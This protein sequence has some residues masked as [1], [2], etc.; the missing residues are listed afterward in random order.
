MEPSVTTIGE[1]DITTTSDKRN[2]NIFGYS[3]PKQEVV[4]FCQI[5]ALYIVI[6]FCLINISIR[7]GDNNLWFSMLAGAVGYLLP[8][9][10][11]KKETIILQ[12]SGPNSI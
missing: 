2:W 9:P 5:I 4:F 7:N 11:L 12:G 10:T 6:L 1:C 8:N 3:I